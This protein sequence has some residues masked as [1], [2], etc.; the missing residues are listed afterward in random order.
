MDDFGFEEVRNL[1]KI[2]RKFIPNIDSQPLK[3]KRETILA[4]ASRLTNCKP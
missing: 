3:Q 1:K 2:K 4:N